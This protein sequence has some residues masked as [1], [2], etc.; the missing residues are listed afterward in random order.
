[1]YALKNHWRTRKCQVCRRSNRFFYH[2]HP[3]ISSNHTKNE[4]TAW[5][6]PIPSTRIMGNTMSYA[7]IMHIL[8][9]L[10]VSRVLSEERRKTG[11]SSMLS[12]AKALLSI[13]LGRCQAGMQCF[14]LLH[15]DAQAVKTLLGSALCAW[16]RCDPPPPAQ[17]SYV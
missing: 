1:M 16:V 10:P 7:G 9:P 5:N 4:T 14:F 8:R 17:W 2:I 15:A 3:Q 11:W 6:L 13:V 12:V